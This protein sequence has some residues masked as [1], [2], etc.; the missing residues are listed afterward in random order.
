MDCPYC[1]KR[2]KAGWIYAQSFEIA[3][4]PEGK[5]P[6]KLG[7]WSKNGLQ[8]GKRSLRRTPGVSAWNCAHCGIL[9]IDVKNRSQVPDG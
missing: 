2:M 7:R 6:P 3:W 4:F 1:H 9:L 8:L 5:R